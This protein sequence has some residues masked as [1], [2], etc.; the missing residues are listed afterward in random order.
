[1]IKFYKDFLVTFVQLI[2]NAKSATNVTLK[3]ADDQ[4]VQFL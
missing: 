4:F 3:S 2:G 1:M